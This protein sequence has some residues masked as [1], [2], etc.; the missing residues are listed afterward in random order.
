MH[1]GP[2]AGLALLKRLETDTRVSSSRRFHAVR[3]H[4]L[5]L[6]GDESGGVSRIPDRPQPRDQYSSNGAIYTSKSPDCSTR[7]DPHQPSPTGGS[8]HIHDDPATPRPGRE[9]ARPNGH[10]RVRA[11]SHGPHPPAPRTA[12]LSK[13]TLPPAHSPSGA[14]LRDPSPGRDPPARRR[15]RNSTVRCREEF[16]DGVGDLGGTFLGGK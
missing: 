8:S 16:C 6:S 7:P 3:A 5:E 4:L 14:P 9:V 10:G 2:P 1:A 15:R 12:V 13:R 11:T